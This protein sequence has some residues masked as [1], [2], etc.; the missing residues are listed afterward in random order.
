M[1]EQGR[2]E[3]PLGVSRLTV[4]KTV[5]FNHLGTAP[6]KQH[7]HYRRKKVSPVG[8]TY[9]S[10]ENGGRYRVRTYDLLYVKQMLSQ[11]S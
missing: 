7:G 4:F 8:E 6:K 1:A 3:L 5:P 9:F 2:F 10:L 11:L